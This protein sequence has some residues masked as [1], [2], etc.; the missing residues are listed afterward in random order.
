MKAAAEVLGNERGNEETFPAADMEEKPGGAESFG[1]SP[2]SRFSSPERAAE[3][4]QGG[5]DSEEETR[6]Q[7]IYQL[8][9]IT[10]LNIQTYEGATRDGRFHGEGVAS[11][12][13]GHEY[14]G[15]FSEGLMDGPGT[16]TQADGVKYEGEFVWNVP[17]GQGTFT[18]PDGSTYVGEV[19]RGLRQGMGTYKC[20]K[21]GVSYRGQWHRGKRHGKGTVYYNEDKTSW[22]E[23]DWVM[24]ER[25]GRGE[26]GYPSGNVYIGEWR[27]NQRHGEGTM[28]WMKVEQ[29]YVGNWQH[30]V[31][32]GVGT[33][34]WFLKR[35]NGS[36][37]AQSNQYKGDFFEGRRHGKGTFYYAGGATY[38]GEWRSDK[39]HG[40]GKLTA[41]SGRVFECEFDDDLLIAS[42]NEDRAPT[43]LGAPP[44]LESD[45]SILGPH[46]ALNIEGIL[47][48]IPERDR[49]TERKQV[50]CAVLSQH[51]EL[52]LI[53]GFYSR[54]GRSYP[55]D[56]IF[57]LS[58]LQFWRLLKD[59]KVHH[60]GVTLAQMDR[61]IREEAG[62]TETHSPFTSMQLHEFLTGLVIV[63]YYIYR[64]DMASQKHCLAACLSRLMTDDILPNARNVK[65]FLFRRPELTAEAL[66]NANRCWEIFD[67]FCRLYGAHR[68]LPSMTCRQLLWMFKD[69]R[70][71]DHQLTTASLLEL[72]TAENGGCT[73]QPSCVELEIV[74]LE[75]F[76][77]LL[78]CAELKF[79]QVPDALGQGLV[80]IT[81]HS[82]TTENSPDVEAYEKQV[83]EKGNVQD[84]GDE[85]V[86][87]QDLM[88]PQLA[89]NFQEHEDVNISGTGPRD[90]VQSKSLAVQRF[91]NDCFFPAV[92]H[93]W[94]VTMQME[95]TQEVHDGKEFQCRE[96][97]S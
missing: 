26:R 90:Q 32:H 56:N 48:K 63:A 49:E 21:S 12:Q 18:W 71:F 68:D 38:T 73:K 97:S 53:F 45:S 41:R 40:Q 51:L 88:S 59:C 76:E 52:R 83:E 66:K 64:K 85:E 61:F 79:Q 44:L 19:Y 2:E 91:F 11:F 42:L 30:G 95:I 9:D 96:N 17:S 39:K 25:E 34:I 10:C 86:Q 69:L 20:A 89:E 75:F 84:M 55:P 16:F 22:Y 13:G 74:F 14:Q 24:N 62:L 70:L 58:R 47:D 54:L 31:Q 57:L 8:P 60:H 4:L 87:N 65:G 77:V 23:G 29:Q 36:Q 35:V 92:D 15:H 81:S 28:T 43:P 67:H 78:G 93:H 3:A 46:M 1:S 72:I 80:Q 6:S 5:S 37:Y 27:N 82:R 94:L 33:H 7:D 50:E